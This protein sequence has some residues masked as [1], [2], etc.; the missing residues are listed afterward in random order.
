MIKCHN[1]LAETAPPA[2]YKAYV[3]CGKCGA[4]TAA[5]AA[6]QSVSAKPAGEVPEVTKE[7]AALAWQRAYAEGDESGVDMSLRVARQV[8]SLLF[9]IACKPI[10]DAPKTL[11]TAL[12]QY[13]HNY[14]ADELIAGYDYDETNRIVA[15]LQ[16][17]AV[18]MPERKQ[19]T[20]Y[21][22]GVVPTNRLEAEARIDAWNACLD[23]VARLNGNG[24][25]V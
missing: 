7:L 5:T 20:R 14:G 2:P 22:S 18:V 25:D 21:L 12:R 3:E 24:G 6:M 9:P 15:A 19:Y 11:V 8:V 1:C 13:R 16:A 23:E 10:V 17:R 4:K